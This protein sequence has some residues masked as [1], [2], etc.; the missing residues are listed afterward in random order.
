VASS[1]KAYKK[2]GNQ[3]ASN[4]ISEQRMSRHRRNNLY[5]SIEIPKDSNI[6][7]I[8]ALTGTHA[9][10]GYSPILS[11]KLVNLDNVQVNADFQRQS[12]TDFENRMAD[13]TPIDIDK[14]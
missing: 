2:I 10:G 14:D 1:L 8:Q 13:Q 5:N 6:P 9:R 12:S 3:Q 11:K 7:L 4:E